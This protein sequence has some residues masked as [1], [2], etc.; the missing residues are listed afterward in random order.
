MKRSIALLMCIAVVFS[1]I[2]SVV[3]ADSSHEPQGANDY[4]IERLP[5]TSQ[6]NSV[7][8]NGDK[9][10]GTEREVYSKLVEMIPL[11]ASGSRASTSFEMTFEDIG[12]QRSYTASD[13]GVESIIENDSISEQAVDAL[14]NRVR[15][16]LDRV[17]KCLLADLPYDLYWF[18]KTGGYAQDEY[19]IVAEYSEDLGTFII[20]ISND[21][22]INLAVAAEYAAGEYLVD[23]ELAVAASGALAKARSIV[24]QYSGVSDYDK[25]LG[26]KS[27]ICGFVSYDHEAAGN[28]STP[29]GNPWQMIW[30]FD[31]DP[32][33]N[34]VCEG[35]AKAFQYLCDITEFNSDMIVCRTVTGTMKHGDS[36]E[37]HMWNVITMDNGKN[38]L[39]D[40]TNCDTGAVGADDLLFL[41]G[42]LDGDVYSPYRIQCGTELI[43]Y[44][45]DYDTLLF[46]H[47]PLE[48]CDSSYKTDS[49][50]YTENGIKYLISGSYAAVSGYEGEPENIVIPDTVNGAVVTEIREAAFKGCASL[51]SISIP[52]TVVSIKSGGIQFDW[53]T[54]QY[55]L[56]GAFTD[57]TSLERVEFGKDSH[58]ASIGKVTFYNCTSLKT[59]SWPATVET[60]PE[61]C[62]SNCSSL[63]TIDLPEGLREI[64]QNALSE[65]SIKSLLL[66]STLTEFCDWMNMYELESITVSDGNQ[67]YRSEDGILYGINIYNEW[68]LI[69]YPWKKTA[70]VYRVPDF[71][72]RSINGDAIA[73]RDHGYYD[74]GFEPRPYLEIVDIGTHEFVDLGR[75][76]QRIIMDEN[77]PYYTIVD[78]VVYD[79]DMKT[80]V[81][82]PGCI[83]GEFVIPDGVTTVGEL[84][85]DHANVTSIV[86][87]ETLINFKDFAFCGCPHLEKITMP[88]EVGEFGICVFYLDHEL[89]DVNIPK[90]ISVLPPSTFSECTELKSISIPDNITVI[91]ESAFAR[92]YKL[93]EIGI[94]IRLDLGI[95]IRL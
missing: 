95:V 8:L 44:Q 29:Y 80:V 79:K 22:C 23:T 84:A 36:S 1:M 81:S 69:N 93:K 7:W 10:S 73:G 92:C 61:S 51:K 76:S 46:D 53:D 58:I 50:E 56:E 6:L 40:V 78:D 77:N 3:F 54:M 59:F 65:T 86:L 66:P 85:F 9:L 18:D 60:I 49:Y 52:D 88:D 11:V 20:Y 89:T 82:V 55:H 43:S 16:D 17:I 74:G 25:L 41:V 5:G 45:Y 14:L 62:F 26:Y 72:G 4:K 35:Y 68:V 71:V 57:C 90:N 67:S 42:C 31:D 38:Y 28:S 64:G 15:F 48:L 24:E 34:V 30:V 33:T 83:T 39:V 27:A 87:P 32:S 94:T 37:N 19:S 13:L 12:L 47:G 63:Q 21:I 2:P 91:S 70:T 75:L